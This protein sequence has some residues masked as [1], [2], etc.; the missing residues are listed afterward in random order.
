MFWLSQKVDNTL[1][2]LANKVEQL[3]QQAATEHAHLLTM[4][5]EQSKKG[6]WEYSNKMKNS[7]QEQISSLDKVNEV[8]YNNISV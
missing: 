2:T 8:H 6:V 1:N 7:L 5:V 4:A 3:E